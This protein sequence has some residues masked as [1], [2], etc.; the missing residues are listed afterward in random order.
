MNKNDK[1]MNVMENVKFVDKAPI[2]KYLQKP[3]NKALLETKGKNKIYKYLGSIR[4]SNCSK[5]GLKYASFQCNADNNYMIF[6]NS[7]S[8]E[9]YNKNLEELKRNLLDDNLSISVSA[10]SNKS[11]QNKNKIGSLS[12]FDKIK[13]NFNIESSNSSNKT[14]IHIESFITKDMKENIKKLIIEKFNKRNNKIVIDNIQRDINIITN[15]VTNRIKEL[16][17]KVNN[18]SVK[19]D[20]YISEIKLDQD[21]F[22]NYFQ[23]IPLN[24][25]SINLLLDL[26]INTKNKYENLIDTIELCYNILLFNTLITDKYM[27]I[28][29]ELKNS[30]KDDDFTNKNNSYFYFIKAFND[31]NNLYNLY[32]P[33]NYEINQLP[34]CNYKILSIKDLENYINQIIKIIAPLCIPYKKIEYL[35]V[36]FIYSNNKK[37]ENIS[38]YLNGFCLENEIKNIIKVENPK[39]ENLPNLYYFLGKDINFSEFDL[40]CLI[41]ENEILTFNKSAFDRVANLHNLIFL[42]NI[43]DIEGLAL[44]FFEIKS[45]QYKS[46]ESIIEGLLK[47]V[48]FLYP[49]LQKYLDSQYKI[50]IEKCTFYFVYIFD[51]KFNQNKFGMPNIKQLL[52]RNKDIKITNE[53]KIIFIHAETNIGQFNLIKLNNK[54]ENLEQEMNIQKL[55][56]KKE[57]DDL[58][59]RVN[60]LEKKICEN[61]MNKNLPQ[62]QENKHNENLPKFGFKNLK[63]HKNELIYICAKKNTQKN[64]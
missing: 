42:D 7:D 52:S 38:D 31:K 51:S 56:H 21:N 18:N 47:K 41:K 33:S 46:N 11:S 61:Q 15:A 53:S 44:A 60:S 54:V 29:E 28:L 64:E 37:S 26:F 10:I 63:Y 9:D 50:K 16:N 35:L 49:F 36:E 6:L 12:I 25:T 22:S 4:L 1:V 13:Y 30:V 43:K 58:M 55:A 20:K 59:N 40:I 3:E 2:I 27:D 19:K 8:M 62:I 5:T 14:K 23:E 39:I 34:D 32:F 48:N 24:E 57:M 45:S 17:E